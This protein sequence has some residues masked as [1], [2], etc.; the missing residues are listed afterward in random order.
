MLSNKRQSTKLEIQ[1]IDKHMATPHTHTHV[2]GKK[3]VTKSKSVKVIT[4]GRWYRQFFQKTFLYFL[5]VSE[6]FRTFQT[7]K[8]SFIKE[9]Q[10]LF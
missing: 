5:I 2:L 6:I 7:A 8:L 10:V 1:T 9:G 4:W 3:C